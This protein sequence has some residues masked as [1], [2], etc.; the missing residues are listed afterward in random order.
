[1]I[2]VFLAFPWL[3]SV[4][5]QVADRRKGAR[6]HL[7][8]VLVL[9]VHVYNVYELMAASVAHEINFVTQHVSIAIEVLLD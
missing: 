3:S 6:N 9:T 8:I 1:M 4:P 2:S 5:E 7:T